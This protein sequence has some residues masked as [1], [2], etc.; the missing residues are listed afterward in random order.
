[1]EQRRDKLRQLVTTLQIP[2]QKGRGQGA[3][4]ARPVPLC[5]W[6]MRPA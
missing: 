5:T 3:R 2:T 4:R 1:M 6:Y